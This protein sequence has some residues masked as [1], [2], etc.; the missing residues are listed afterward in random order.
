M[1]GYASKWDDFAD[2]MPALAAESLADALGTASVIYGECEPDPDGDVYVTFAYLQDA[3]LMMT[4]A[5][6]TACKPGS[7]LDR[8]SA[9]CITM[10]DAVSSGRALTEEQI[11]QVV[12]GS[13]TWSI[14]PDMQGS[15]VGWHVSVCMP[16]SDAMSV[17]AALNSVSQTRG[18]A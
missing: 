12:G 4:L 9:G 2:D 14:H 3:E 17:A 13:W 15:R 8:A 11:D 18:E 1:D 16:S 5:F 6:N 10:T 7:M